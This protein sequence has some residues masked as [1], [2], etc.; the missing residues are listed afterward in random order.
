MK[1]AFMLGAAALVASCVFAQDVFAQRGGF[2]EAWPITPS[3]GEDGSHGQT[4]KPTR[5]TLL[6]LPNMSPKCLRLGET[7]SEML[8]VRLSAK[9]SHGTGPKSS[10]IFGRV[11]S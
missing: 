11:K 8:G 7:R 1:S 2:R 4:V 3:S 5:W 10:S 9:P 6:G